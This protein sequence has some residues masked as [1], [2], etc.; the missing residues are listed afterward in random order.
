MRRKC[1]GIL[2]KIKNYWR[3]G[4]GVDFGAY[5]GGLFFSQKFPR[6][7][8]IQSVFPSYTFSPMYIHRHLFPGR[9]VVHRR[10]IIPPMG[11]KDISAH[12]A[13]MNVR[14]LT[15]KKFFLLNDFFHI[16]G[17]GL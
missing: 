10:G 17:F 1:G 7:S 2:M 15:K 12:L 3:F 11:N 6:L 9:E 4:S 8:W 5:S 13:I 14:S 16:M